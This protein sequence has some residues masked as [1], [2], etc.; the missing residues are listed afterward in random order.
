M[1]KSKNATEKSIEKLLFLDTLLPDGLA[2]N[3]LI[4]LA[5]RPQMGKSSFAFSVAYNAVSSGIPV[6]FVSLEYPASQIILR[7]TSM[8]SKQKPQNIKEE[9]LNKLI[10]EINSLP[11]FIDDTSSLSIKELKE[12][13]Q[14]WKAEKNV[15]LIIV[16]YLQL[17][18]SPEAESR[19]RSQEIEIIM[20]VLKEIARELE[21]PVLAF[22]QLNQAIT[23]EKIPTLLDFQESASIASTADIVMFL[24]RPEYYLKDVENRDEILEQNNWKDLANFIVAKNSVGQTGT[25]DLTCNMEF[26][27]FENRNKVVTA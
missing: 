16:D 3:E 18:K 19:T 1:C 2:G 22:A 25:I 10:S 26:G 17:I 6:G 27:T 14:R 24:R 23:G 13:C 5:S 12:K 15:G 8:Q 9:E 20:A 4:I 11:L 21:V 7:A